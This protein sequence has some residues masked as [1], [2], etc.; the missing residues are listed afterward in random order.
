M[1][2]MKSVSLALAIALG[3]TPA[4]AQ[5]PQPLHESAA[6]T[7][8]AEAAEQDS[9]SRRAKL[10]WTGLAVGVAGV[11]TAV[12]GSTV[13]RV[14]TSSTGNAPPNAY[15]ACVAQQKDPI[16]A[17]NQCDGL[18]AKNVTLLASGIALGA[19]GAALIIGSAHTSAEIGPGVVR[20]VHRIRF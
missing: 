1:A 19:V 14:E 11:T 16:Y 10:F 20:V 4:L 18:K 6:R 9:H 8:V 3:A 2:T 12:L 5:P 13:Y 17:S 7:A 15:Q